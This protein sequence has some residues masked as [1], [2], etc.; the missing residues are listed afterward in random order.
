MTAKYQKISL[1]VIAE[2]ELTAQLEAFVILKMWYTKLPFIQEKISMR[3][4][5]HI[6][7]SRKFTITGIPSP[8]LL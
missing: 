4:K 3:K 6:V 7:I 8:M 1:L 2:S 5:V